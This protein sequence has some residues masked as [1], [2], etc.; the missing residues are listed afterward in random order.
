M[1]FYLELPSV[2]V[3][4]LQFMQEATAF[5]LL[6][7]IPEP[8]ETDV[9]SDS[10]IKFTIVNTDATG[11]SNLD[12]DTFINSV[13]AID[14][15]SFINGYSGSFIQIDPDTLSVEIFPPSNFNSLEEVE[16][17]VVHAGNPVLLDETYSF[18]AEDLSSP[19]IDEVITRD[20]K[21]IRVS[22]SETLSI[23]NIFDTSNYSI[24]RRDADL[25]NCPAVNLSVVNVELI[26]DN[27]IE[28]ETDIVMTPDGPYT[29][30]I[31]NITDI[32]D[33]PIIAPFNNFDF[34]GFVPEIPD[35][36][37]FDLYRM[38]PQKNRDEDASLD[39]YRF[40]KCLQEITNLN[41]TSVDRWTNILDPDLAPENYLDAM[42]A[43][44]G[45]PFD[46]ELDVTQKRKLI[47]ILL[48]IYKQKGTAVGIINVIRF[49]LG[50]EV[51]IETA[52]GEAVLLGEG[53]LGGSGVGEEGDFVLGASIDFLKYSFIVISPV[54]LDAGQEEIL[55]KIVDY[56]KPAHTHHIETQQP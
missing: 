19:I 28:I 10:S 9:A 2:Y 48:A 54:T 26:E 37:F 30:V 1:S 32:F 6:N 50:I 3:D 16:V 49:F 53:V 7:R 12:V 46:F 41:L 5:L 39:L 45:N 20:Q 33:N 29:L 11:I 25:N 42:L 24:L 38:L 23:D 35:G 55:D 27:V 40:I 4:D 34:L 14:D 36:R 18:F 8:T 17:Q 47:K 31:S 52:T 22:F 13:Q 44:L 56:M 21:I 51:E 43:D 15:G